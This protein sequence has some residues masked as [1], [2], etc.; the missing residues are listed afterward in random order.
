MSNGICDH[1]GLPNELSLQECQGCGWMEM[2]ASIATVAASCS[3]CGE[4]T[5]SEPLGRVTPFKAP[6]GFCRHMER[7]G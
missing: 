1:C 5:Y 7:M 2:I 6:E 3:H 4:R